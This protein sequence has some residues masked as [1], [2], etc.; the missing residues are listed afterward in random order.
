M[1]DYQECVT[2]STASVC[3]FV[4][5]A[6][7]RGLPSGPARARHLHRPRVTLRPGAYVRPDEL[8]SDVIGYDEMGTW[9]V[10]SASGEWTERVCMCVRVALV[11]GHHCAQ[12]RAREQP[13]ARERDQRAGREA[14]VPRLPVRAPSLVVVSVLLLRTNH[15]TKQSM[16]PIEPKFQNAYMYIQYEV[17]LIFG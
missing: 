11:R 8:R 12:R 5:C 10:R 6:E 1:C 13:E 15:I 16:W 4:L 14:P 17:I 7:G 3:C 2:M 9:M